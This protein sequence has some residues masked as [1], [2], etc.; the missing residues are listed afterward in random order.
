[1]CVESGIVRGWREGECVV[2]AGLGSKFVGRG[3]DGDRRDEELPFRV[4]VLHP[5]EL[6]SSNGGLTFH[7][8]DD[9]FARTQTLGWMWTTYLGTETCK[10][11]NLSSFSSNYRFGSSLASLK[12]LI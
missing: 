3:R 7:P 2:S 1:M 5:S 6:G 9:A 10:R 11:L 8:V 12:V 4:G